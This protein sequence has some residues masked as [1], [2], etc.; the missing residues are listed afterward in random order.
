MTVPEPGLFFMRV[1]Q[2]FASYVY[3][4]LM[5]VV[6]TVPKYLYP[7][8]TLHF[9]LNYLFKIQKL[10]NCVS[11]VTCNIINKYNKIHHL[12]VRSFKYHS[13]TRHAQIIRSALR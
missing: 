9:G 8:D 10:L 7:S 4:V 13:G 3:T 1:M 5:S 12:K 2:S 11:V 6:L